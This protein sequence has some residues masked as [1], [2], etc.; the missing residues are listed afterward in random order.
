MRPMEIFEFALAA[1]AGR[2]F[3]RVAPHARAADVD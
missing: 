1:T 2:G 3:V